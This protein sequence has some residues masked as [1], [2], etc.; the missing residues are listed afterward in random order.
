MLYAVHYFAMQ[1]YFQ[2][3]TCILSVLQFMRLQRKYRPRPSLCG[4]FVASDACFWLNVIPSIRIQGTCRIISHRLHDSQS[5]G[6]AFTE[7]YSIPYT[8]V[9]WPLNET[10]SNGSAIPS[11]N[12]SPVNVYDCTRLRDGTNVKHGLVLGLNGGGVT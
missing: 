8:K 3:P 7:Q 5:F 2:P 11:P 6:S 9:L 1:Y 4:R 12:E 10:K